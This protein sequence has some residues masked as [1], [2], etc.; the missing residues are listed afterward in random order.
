MT[1]YNFKNTEAK[2][3]ETWDK[4]GCFEVT[5]DPSRPKYYV[6]EMFPYPSGRIH[7]GHVR[8][9]TLGD[10]VARYKRARGF[11][12]LHP[13]GWDAFGL[14]A[15]N[16]AIQNNVPP[17]QWTRRNID[18]MREQLKSMGFSYD[19]SR[20]L[21][22]C[23][24]DYYRHEQKMFLD[25]L[26]AGL[27]Y[28]KE[29]WVNWD[30]VE[31]TVLANEQVI[32]GK[33]WRSGAT[34]EKRQ[35]S[36][37]FLRITHYADDLLD[38]LKDLERWPDRV[39][40]MQENWIGRSEGARMFFDLKGRDDRLEV[41]TTRQDTIF[42]A[43]FCAIAAN[44]PIARELAADNPALAE[45]IAECD[46]L[47]TSEAAI[48]T[49]EKL[50]F[51]TG[52]RA[53]HPFVEGK[54]LRI[55][56]ANF[57]L[58]E[59]G[60]GA[61]FGCPAHDQRDLDFARKYGL[62]V[63]P[64]VAPEGTKPADFVIEND[65][66]TGEGLH[67]NSSFLDGTTIEAA[68]DEI[69]ERLSAKNA[70]EKA[71]NY[72]LRDW[73]V[74][75]QRYWGCPIP[76]IRCDDCGMVPVP[77]AELPVILPEDVTIG[78]AGNPLDTHP[79]WKHVACP[80]CGKPAERETDTFDTFFESSWYFERFC[81]ASDDNAFARDAVDYW[82]PVDQYIGGI[83]H[84][85][86]HLLYSRFFTRALKDCG[87]LSAKEPFAGLMT[88]GM[89]CHQT[90]RDE[91]GGWVLPTDVSTKTDGSAVHISTGEKISVGRSEKMSKSKRNVV[92]PEE[93]LASYG[94]DTARLFMLSDSPPK[95]D[96]DWTDAGVDG[97][98]RYINRLWR[99]IGET[100][101]AYCAMGAPEPAGISAEGEAI[102]RAV[103]KTI[104][105]VSDDL[106][107]FHFN[108]AVARIR[109]LTNLLEGLDVNSK[110]GAWVLRFGCE[111]VV[112][113]IGPMM[114]HLAE[115]LWERL[116]HEGLLVDAGWPEFDSAYLEETS[117]TIAVQVN[118]KLR[119][120]VDMPKDSA[121]EDVELAA[122]GVDNVVSAMNGK[123]ARKVIV[124]PNRIVNVV[125]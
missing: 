124:V 86:L 91:A 11:N 49:A 77:E 6:L 64:V 34:V 107:R 87:Y 12:V 102:R 100:P 113:L 25:F 59:Y 82:M 106:E 90:F 4:R 19:W 53:L 27:A 118:G 66:Y 57:V 76:I 31:Q 110:G 58:M 114:P 37:W 65:A 15:E 96:L 22:T 104:A 78:G 17:A 70:G 9:Y 117:V 47:G 73:G 85:V 26:K 46:R 24:P 14:P 18:T 16:A 55:F 81:S 2:W 116:G 48:E 112:K 20:E 92:D 83:E 115:E 60:T 52:L 109:E 79:T 98:W 99:L 63:V 75:R 56:V 8:N 51:D 74:S 122:L 93:I 38:A 40:L 28:R 84:A 120:T 89:I 41:Y 69:A 5:E 45:F 23:E 29:S 108:K 123:D 36:Q 68:K 35:L 54:E 88:Q 39:R 121:K 30:P 62:E 67:I 1:R 97:A 32:D 42:G 3:Q 105:A 7:M 125:V 13:M 10:L 94:A 95:H 33:G 111:A 21:A 43:S 72:R 61:I 44:H 50:G 101:E 119:G 71:I 80:Q 103:H